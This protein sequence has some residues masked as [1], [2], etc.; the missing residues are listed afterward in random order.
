MATAATVPESSD[1]RGSGG[2]KSS[3]GTTFGPLQQV[4]DDMWW[5]W[6]TVKFMPGIVFP[7]NM[8]VVREASGDLVVIHPVMMPDAQQRQ[9]EALGPIKHIVR[10]GAFHG[11]DDVKFVK[12]Y[13][14]TV[15]APPGC[16][17]SPEMKFDRELVPGGETPI[18]GARVFA[19]ATSRSPETCLLVPRHGGVLLTCD[20]VQNWETGEGCSVLGKLMARLMGFRGRACIGPGWRKQSE[21]KNGIGFRD[22]FRELLALEFRH[23]L[24]GHGAPLQ[25]TARDDLRAQVA[26]LYKS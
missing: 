25:D 11:M 8:T 19:F 13:A 23:V 12:R 24:S 20:S 9:L 4:F 3:P 14:P 16:A 2:F 26:K 15:W 6:G 5:A 17:C 1:K 18:A 10:L 21:P 7:R 22:S